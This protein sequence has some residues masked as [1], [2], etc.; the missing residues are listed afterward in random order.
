M[1]G[2]NQAAAT[3]SNI[4]LIYETRNEEVEEEDI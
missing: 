4:E 2:S 3:A 1:V